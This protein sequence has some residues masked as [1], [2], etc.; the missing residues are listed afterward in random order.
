VINFRFRPVH[1]E[2]EEWKPSGQLEAIAR[3]KSGRLS[4]LVATNQSAWGGA[5]RHAHADAIHDKMTRP[6]RW[7]AHASTRCFSARTRRQ[8]LH[9]RKPKAGMLEEIAARYKPAWPVCCGG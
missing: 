5:V 3:L 9:C 8:P 7:Q 1:Q 6:A 2:P 4:L